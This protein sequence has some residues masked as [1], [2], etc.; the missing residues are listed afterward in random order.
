MSS[1]DFCGINSDFFDVFP[2]EVII[3]EDAFT[4]CLELFEFFVFEMFSIFFSLSNTQI[5]KQYYLVF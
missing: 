5:L 2:R 1:V 4:E 3:V